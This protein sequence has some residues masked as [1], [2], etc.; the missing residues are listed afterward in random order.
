MTV[1]TSIAVIPMASSQTPGRSGY[2]AGG[3]RLNRTGHQELGRSLG[4]EHL[5]DDD[6]GGIALE[7]F[8]AARVLSLSLRRS[9]TTIRPAD[10]RPT[11][12][13]AAGDAAQIPDVESRPVPTGM[14]CLTARPASTV[15]VV[16]VPYPSRRRWD[17]APAVARTHPPGA[18][19]LCLSHARFE[20]HDVART[21]LDQGLPRSSTA[22][23]Q[24]ST[25][26]AVTAH[27]ARRARLAEVVGAIARATDVGLGLPIEHAVRTCLL[28]LEMGRRIGLRCR[29]RFLALRRVGEGESDEQAGRRRSLV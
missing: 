20:R 29:S 18:G 19:P 15:P 8:G 6:T 26:S 4:E 9:R 14:H 28:S 13:V 2:V 27:P 22:M 23:P 5:A 24:R 10:E 17:R 21:C 16:A 25:V 12:V 7:K 1:P 3:G 11:A